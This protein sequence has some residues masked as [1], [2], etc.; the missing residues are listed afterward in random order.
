M[1][2]LQVPYFDS[3]RFAVNKHSARC[4]M[5]TNAINWFE[6]PSTDFERAVTFYE[7]LFNQTLHRMSIAMPGGEPMVMAMLPSDQDGVGGAVVSVPEHR[8]GTTGPLVYLNA[9]PDVA[10]LVQRAAANG[11]TIVLPKTEIGEGIGYMAIIL[12][13]EGNHIGMH[14]NQ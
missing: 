8:P 7:A 11:G 5:P 2:L 10:V 14:S 9:N 12:D 3:G 13:T 4:P 1:H 6:I